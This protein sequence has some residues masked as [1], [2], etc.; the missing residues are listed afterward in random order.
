[1]EWEAITAPRMGS[2]LE[3]CPHGATS[4]CQDRD[5]QGGE[6]ARRDRLS[7]QGVCV[8][9]PHPSHGHTRTRP[10]SHSVKSDVLVQGL[11]LVR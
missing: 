11:P 3:G 6:I 1:M 2:V 7:E 5:L 10:R 8:L 4:T 9:L